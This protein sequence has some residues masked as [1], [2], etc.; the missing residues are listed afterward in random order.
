MSQGCSS[1]ILCPSRPWLQCYS[2]GYKSSMHRRLL[3]IWLSAGRENHTGYARGRHLSI[4]PSLALITSTWYQRKEAKSEV[5]D[6]VLWTGWRAN[7]RWYPVVC[8]PACCEYYFS[9]LEND[10]RRHWCDQ[11]PHRNPGGIPSPSKPSISK[12]S[13]QR[14]EE[15]RTVSSSNHQSGVNSS[16][17]F[18]KPSQILNAF[19]DPQ[20]WLLCLITILCSLPSGVITTFSAALI[21]NFGYTSKQSALLNIPGG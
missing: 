12:V 1:K 10:V 16:E 8:F 6:L 17:K 4:S 13:F 20:A 11:H 3:L 9:G 15:S 19:K 7:L 5:R 2:L 18:A 21:H 14:K